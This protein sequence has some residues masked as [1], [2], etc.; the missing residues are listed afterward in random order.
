MIRSRHWSAVVSVHSCRQEWNPVVGVWPAG[1]S[2]LPP[3]FGTSSYSPRQVVRHL[4][5]GQVWN[6]VFLSIVRKIR[7]KTTPSY[8]MTNYGIRIWWVNGVWK[9]MRR[10][11]WT[12]ATVAGSLMAAT[13][14]LCR[15]FLPA[16]MTPMAAISAYEEYSQTGDRFRGVFGIGQRHSAAISG[17]W[18]G[19]PAS[20][21][22]QRDEQGA[23]GAA[24]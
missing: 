1:F 18:T 15:R 3:Y 16:Q 21:P 13:S 12:T 2:G 10:P 14:T 5:R 24:V 9:T 4:R 19:G 6:S 22:V 7:S 20:D 17:C 23:F 11:A 8:F